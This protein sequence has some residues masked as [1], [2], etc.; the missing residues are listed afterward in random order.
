MVEAS[1]L[2]HGAEVARLV[3]GAAE[4]FPGEVLPTVVADLADSL[5]H[6]EI[7]SAV[8][9]ADLAKDG[10]GVVRVSAHRAFVVVAETEASE[11]ALHPGAGEDSTRSRAT[12]MGRMAAAGGARG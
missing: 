2:D 10:A 11:V 8:V 12:S 4:D 9:A 1:R 5:A 6:V 7:L 3:R